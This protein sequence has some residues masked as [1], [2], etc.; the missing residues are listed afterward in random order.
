VA[1]G[2]P[3]CGLARALV[4]RASPQGPRSKRASW[5]TCLRQRLGAGSPGLAGRR[6]KVAV[7]GD[8]R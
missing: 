2:L 6:R 1:H 5:G 4:H 7:A 3:M 8:A